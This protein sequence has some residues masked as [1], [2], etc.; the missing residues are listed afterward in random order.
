MTLPERAETIAIRTATRADAAA[1]AVLGR[2]TFIDTFG[3]ANTAADLAMFLDATYGEALQQRELD[4][5]QQT[6]FIVESDGVLLAFALL[7][8]G[9]SSP[10]V[11]DPAAVE[12]RRFYVDRAAHGTGMAQRLMAR[13]IAYA[14]EHFAPVVYL[15]VWERNT[16]AIRFYATQGFTT[17]GVQPYRLGNDVQQDLVLVR[18]L[19]A[20]DSRE[21]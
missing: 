16:R 13:C 19:D 2:R 14:G 18:R 10:L 8:R 20:T 1:L 4:D 12:I 11:P 15:G 6:C 21:R 5:P 3:D 7:R 9:A 17:A